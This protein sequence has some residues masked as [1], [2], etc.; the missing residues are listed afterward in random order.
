MLSNPDMGDGVRGNKEEIREASLDRSKKAQIDVSKA[1]QFFVR[2]AKK[3]KVSRQS[4]EISLS[5]AAQSACGLL[6]GSKT[7][8]DTSIG[9]QSVGWMDYSKQANKEL[10]QSSPHPSQ[11]T[12]DSQTLGR[13]LLLSALSACVTL[14]FSSLR[15]VPG[16]E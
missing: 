3:S 13:S 16:T 14:Y 1:Q 5:E 10:C 8:N 15:L 4:R 12:I 11:R 9:G 6:Q 7:L 2:R